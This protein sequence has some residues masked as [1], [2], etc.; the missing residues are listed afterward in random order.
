MDVLTLGMSSPKI[1][2]VQQKLLE[3]GLFEGTPQ[4]NFGSR[5]EEAVIAFQHQVG[6][7]E[8]GQV[9][10]ETWGLLMVPQE[11][12]P[13]PGNPPPPRKPDDVVPPWLIEALKDLGKGTEE[14]AGP[15]DNPDIVAYHQYTSLKAKDDET[16]W[17]ASS[18]CAWLER[19]GVRSPR[20]AAAADFRNWGKEL[21]EGRLGCLVVMSRPGGNHVFQYL[22]EDA[23][24][25]YGIGGNQGDRVSVTRF[26]WANITNFRWPT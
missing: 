24:G 9:G 5:T 20:S 18:S 1:K 23:N 13:Q 10:D 4:G 17:C 25:V 14:I 21:K 26:A 16:A 8:D 12:T 22:D 2:Q 19:A 15:E 6:I 7:T 11:G 3:L